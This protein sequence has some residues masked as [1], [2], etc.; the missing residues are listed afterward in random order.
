MLGGKTSIEHIL[1][2]HFRAITDVNWHNTDPNLVAST[3]LDGWLWAWDIRTPQKPTLG[4]C[5]FNG[6][7]FEF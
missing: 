3:A 6:A 4:L 2:S 5:A 7:G 1:N